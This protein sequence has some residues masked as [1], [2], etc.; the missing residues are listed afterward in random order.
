MH[1]FLQVK[2]K[3]HLF[4][5]FS[6]ELRAMHPRLEDCRYNVKFLDTLPKALCPYLCMG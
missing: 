2:K 6:W 3:L 4:L 5:F 1:M